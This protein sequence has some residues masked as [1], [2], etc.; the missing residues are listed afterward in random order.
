MAQSRDASRG[1]SISEELMQIKSGPTS[2]R[3]DA[4]KRAWRG[5]PGAGHISSSEVQFYADGRS[6]A[7]QAKDAIP[8]ARPGIG[9]K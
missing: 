1:Y 5:F 4:E 2:A 8:T 6:I 7:W 3:L 9:V